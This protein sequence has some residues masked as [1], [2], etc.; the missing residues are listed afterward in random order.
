MSSYR[1]TSGT[2]SANPR[3]PNRAAA[4]DQWIHGLANA[5]RRAREA[6]ARD[7]CSDNETSRHVV[8]AIYM[9]RRQ[10]GEP[11]P[12]GIEASR[13]ALAPLQPP[14]VPPP[15]TT[16]AMPPSLP[17]TPGAMP[18]PP[19]PAADVGCGYSKNIDRVPSSGL[20]LR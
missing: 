18:P 16:G 14:P 15:P 3:Q 12:E 8:I 1:P 11:L 9:W 7:G 6:A 19:P 2:R 13:R 4:L 20:T 5:R 10:H 17:P